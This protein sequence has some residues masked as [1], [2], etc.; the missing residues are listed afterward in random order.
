M[1]SLVSANKY[2]VINDINGCWVRVFP[3]SI[4]LRLLTPDPPRNP[5]FLAPPH[6]QHVCGRSFPHFSNAPSISAFA[7]D[8][9]G[10][11]N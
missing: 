9:H 5:L 4:T 3:L 7:Y 1:F 10:H 8:F 2:C 11:A 6:R